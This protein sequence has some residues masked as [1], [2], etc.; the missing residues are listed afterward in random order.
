MKRLLREWK[1]FIKEDVQP[2]EFYPKRFDDFLNLMKD[3][4]DHLWVFF[5][6]ETTGLHYKEAHVQVTQIA[7]VVYNIEGITEGKTP[8]QVETLNVK[9]ALTQDVLNKIEQQDKENAGK[10]LTDTEKKRTVRGLLDMNQ[11]FEEGTDYLLMNDAIQQFDD[12]L[13]DMRSKSPSGEIVIIAQNSPFDVGVINTAYERLSLTVPDDKLWDTKAV[14]HTYLTPILGM[15]DKDKNADPKD[16]K[17]INALRKGDKFSSS[18]GDVTKAFDVDNKGW[19]N[20]INDTRMTMDMLF[21]VINYV[22]A[23]Q[24]KYKIDTTSLSTFDAKAGD[25][26]SP[27]RS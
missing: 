20:A 5:D 27:K 12:F 25:P 4:E 15:I 17:I 11:Y 10:E 16:I 23:K 14:L 18:L 3:Y 24:D 21:A 13:K 8:K 2:G 19:H 1:R 26:Y 6:T 22:K 7:C 9:A